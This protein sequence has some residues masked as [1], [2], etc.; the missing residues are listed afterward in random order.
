MLLIRWFNDGRKTN[1]IPNPVTEISAIN[2]RKGIINFRGN[3]VDGKVNQRNFSVC[4][5][6]GIDSGRDSSTESHC[7]TTC[8]MKLC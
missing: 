3:M 2:T 5:F 7:A 4:M 1:N 8:E 6:S